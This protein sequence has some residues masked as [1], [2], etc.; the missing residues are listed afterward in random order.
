MSS[1]GLQGLSVASDSR[2]EYVE[3]LQFALGEGPCRDAYDTGVAVLVGDLSGEGARRWPIYAP[4]A[5]DNGVEAV[6]AFPLRVGVAGIGVLGVYSQEPG[7]LPADALRW[8]PVFA[9]VAMIG[10]LDSYEAGGIPEPGEG[11]A[12]AGALGYRVEVYQAQ[13]MLQVQLG[14]GASEALARLQAH[15]FA[16]GHRITD[17]ARDIIARRLT[18]ERDD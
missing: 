13:G 18:L 3:E 9:E 10:L 6:F 16:G 15:A 11:P 12:P 7:P 14:V 4:A 2:S 17:V 1:N 5:H 8:A